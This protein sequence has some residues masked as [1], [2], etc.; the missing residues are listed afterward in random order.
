MV[1]GVG[2]EPAACSN[3]VPVRSRSLIPDY[4]SLGLRHADARLCA[5]L[6]ATDLNLDL[7]PVQIR[8]LPGSHPE[9]VF[10]VDV[11]A[12]SCRPAPDVECR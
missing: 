10:V 3:P 7:K 8:L 4:G 1:E 2:V 6:Q 9:H 11:L 5:H 12:H